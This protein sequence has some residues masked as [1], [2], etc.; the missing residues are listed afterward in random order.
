MS[1]DSPSP[2][3]P[4][5]PLRRRQ[6]W[7]WACLVVLVL[8]I[9]GLLIARQLIRSLVPT[10]D[11]TAMAFDAQTWRDSKPDF[12]LTSVRLRMV[13]DLLSRSPLV[14]MT[15]DEIE[16]LLGPR[17][18]T[19]YFADADL[20]YFLGQ[21]RHPFGIDSEWLVVRLGPDGRAVTASLATD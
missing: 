21:E 9:G 12:S 16:A 1:I 17:D 7:T 2:T 5:G 19:P 3:V 15:L 6:R 10:V 14:G 8:G 18:D 4:G 13:D 11:F 20:V